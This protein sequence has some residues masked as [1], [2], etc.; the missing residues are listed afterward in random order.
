MTLDLNPNGTNHKLI[1]K[2]KWKN[3]YVK[4]NT[5]LKKKINDSDLDFKT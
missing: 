4:K 3:I 2:F 5:K 1:L